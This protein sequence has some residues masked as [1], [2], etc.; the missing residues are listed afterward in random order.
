MLVP[1]ALSVGTAG[2]CLLSAVTNA[3]PIASPTPPDIPSSSSAKSLLA[4][5]TVATRRSSDGYSRDEFPHWIT[6]SG[7]CDTRE[8]VLKRDGTGVVQSSSCSA[9]SGSWYSPYDGATWTAASDVDIDHVVP[10][11]NAWV[12]RI[13]VAFQ[14]PDYFYLLILD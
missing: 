9:T 10:L 12:V 2:L 5:L 6:I 3:A 13:D 14:Y 8:T 7:S 1:Q 4:G 11:E